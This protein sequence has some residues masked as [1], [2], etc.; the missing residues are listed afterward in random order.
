MEAEVVIVRPLE[1]DGA[2]H[3]LGPAHVE[4]EEEEAGPR[5][6]LAVQ[7]GVGRRVQPHR[8]GGAHFRGHWGQFMIYDFTITEKA[9]TRTFFWLKVP[10]ALN[11][12]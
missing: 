12:R 6:Q 4:A 9:P 2:H 8:A 1:R 3:G 10:I 5:H 7:Q 11:G